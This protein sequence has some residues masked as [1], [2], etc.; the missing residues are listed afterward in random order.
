MLVQRMSVGSL[1]WIRKY[2]EDQVG[3]HGC[4]IRGRAY[5]PWPVRAWKEPNLN[6]Q[7]TWRSEES[8]PTPRAMGMVEVSVLGASLLRMLE[9]LHVSKTSGL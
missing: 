2:V 8:T 7:K 9:T 3:N 4:K 5:G 6:R 1:K